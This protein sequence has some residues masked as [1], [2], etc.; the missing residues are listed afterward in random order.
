MQTHINQIIHPIKA[1]ILNIVT[2]GVREADDIEVKRKA[3]L[4]NVLCSIGIVNLVP[5]G[6][7]AG[8]Q[9]NIGLWIFDHVTASVLFANMVYL[10]ISGNYRL[11]SLCGVFCI[12][13]LYYYLFFTGGV[14]NTAHVWY[15]SYPLMAMFLLGSKRGAFAT[16]VLFVPAII[17]L[18]LKDPPSILATYSTDFKIRFIPSFLVVAAFS[19]SF[20]KIREGNQIKLEQNYSGLEAIVSELQKAQKNYRRIN[21][22]LKE[23]QA[24]LIQTGKLSSIG[25]LSSGIAHELN[26][27]L[28]VIRGNTQF[29]IKNL[30]DGK[31]TREKISKMLSSVEKNTKR[32]MDI[33]NHLRVFSRQSKNEFE[34]ININTVIDECF[35]IVGE[36]L[37]LSNIQVKKEFGLNLPIVN[38][39]A[40]QLEQVFLNLIT[41]ARDAIEDSRNQSNTQDTGTIEITSRES[42][43]NPDFVE[44][45]VGDNGSGVAPESIPVIFDPF[46]T[47]KAVG[48]GTGLGLSISYGIIKDHGGEISV[49]RTSREGT[50]FKVRLPIVR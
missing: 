11:F 8:I 22:E 31:L 12:T 6:I 43:K 21:Q 49:A 1:T 34:P 23:T 4:G 45:T 25:E 26:Q 38:G 33:I 40:I 9:N 10:R 41:N 7:I 42:E 3:V 20:E 46:F 36:K 50:T 44:V 48:K 2:G 24:Q 29:I 39:N 18:L 35:L 13:L 15:Y 5:L 16:L 27:P 30:S 47:T 17:F 14:G 28:M 32:M 19:Y 37:R